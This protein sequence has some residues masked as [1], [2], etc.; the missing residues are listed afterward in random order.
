QR[1]AGGNDGNDGKEANGNLVG[2]IHEL[3]ILLE[4]TTSSLRKQGSMDRHPHSQEQRHRGM[5]TPSHTRV[6]RPRGRAPLPAN[7]ALLIFVAPAKTE[8]Q[9][10]A[11]TARAS[12]PGSRPT[13]GR[14][15][16]NC[17]IE[18][19]LHTHVVLANA[20]FSKPRPPLSPLRA[21]MNPRIHREPPR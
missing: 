21:H 10:S 8:V 3:A 5:H 1:Q 11:R 9:A 15:P 13:P 6:R 17:A 14:P 18:N 7:D 2:W 12:L 19:P 20:A 4:P 16:A